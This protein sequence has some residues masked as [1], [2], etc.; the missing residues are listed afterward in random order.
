MSFSD[1][2][3]NEC[4]CVCVCVNAFFLCRFDKLL[5]IYYDNV[6]YDMLFTDYKH[7]CMMQKACRASITLLNYDN[8]FSHINSKYL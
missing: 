7:P 2:G 8:L 6:M 5:L 1:D 4:L 3:A